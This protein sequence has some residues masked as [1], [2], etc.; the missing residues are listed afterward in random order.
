MASAKHKTSTNP[1]I[2]WIE[3]EDQKHHLFLITAVITATPASTPVVL[4]A[5]SISITRTAFLDWLLKRT[6]QGDS[7]HQGAQHGREHSLQNL[8]STSQLWIQIEGRAT[9]K[10]QRKRQVFGLEMLLTLIE[11]VMCKW[12]PHKEGWKRK[13]YIWIFRF[14]PNY[15]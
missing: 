6:L 2:S 5:A 1:F 3:I 8:A 4:A 15:L 9:I 10:S 11:N 13:P 7:W 12:K 14:L